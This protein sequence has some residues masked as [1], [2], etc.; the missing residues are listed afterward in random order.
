MPKVT[1]LNLTLENQIGELARLCRDL[2]HE[3]INLLALNAVESKESSG[4]VHLLVANRE[5]AEKAL[6]KAGYSFSVEEVILVELKH[7]PGALA[8]QTEK[9]ADKSIGVR[10]AYATANTKAQTTTVVI[11]VEEQDLDRA[12]NLLG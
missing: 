9:L 11:A 3:G 12:S 4:V 10:Y 2:A 5:L 6:S 8:K 1:Q 7:R